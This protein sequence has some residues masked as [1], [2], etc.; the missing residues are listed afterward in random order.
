ML[1]SFV[2]AAVE[3][4]T[5]LYL[6]FICNSFLKAIKQQASHITSGSTTFSHTPNNKKKAE[7]KMRGGGRGAVGRGAGGGGK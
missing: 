3:A 2:I 4:I 5:A 1:F 7:L 6:M